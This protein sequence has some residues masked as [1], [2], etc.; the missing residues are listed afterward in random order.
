MESKRVIT[1]K[2]SSRCTL[3]HFVV[4]ASIAY[5]PQT[6]PG[7]NT[8]QPT[9]V[10]TGSIVSSYVNY[11]TPNKKTCAQ[12]TTASCHLLL[13]RPVLGVAAGAVVA[14]STIRATF[15]TCSV[16]VLLA[17]AGRLRF[18]TTVVGLPRHCGLCASCPGSYICGG[19]RL[20]RISAIALSG[21]WFDRS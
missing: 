17:V 16:L 20:A 15:A 18:S 12:L 8:F 1:W 3:A 10:A 13:G 9:Y 11:A 19:F 21:V 14:L 5:R 6:F 2:R 7:S 4:S